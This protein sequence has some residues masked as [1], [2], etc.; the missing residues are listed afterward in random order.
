MVPVG[1]AKRM[2]E[3]AEARMFWP[4]GEV[5]CGGHLA[6]DFLLD[7]LSGSTGDACAVCSEPS[8][9]FVDLDQLRDLVVGVVRTYRRRAIDELYHDAES[10]SGYAFPDRWMEDTADVVHELFGDALDEHLI[11]PVAFALDQQY[12]FRP[13]LLWLEGAELYME[14]WSS[15]RRLVASTD[16]ELDALLGGVV[17]L[18]SRHSSDV[19]QPSQVLPELLTV[20]EDVGVVRTLAPEA[21]WHRALHVPRGEALSARRL[22][23]APSDKSTENRMNRAGAAMFYGAEDVP[24][25]DAEI[26]VAP[27]GTSAVV[28]TWK[29][30]RPLVV[31]DLVDMGEAP[32]FYDVER[33][34]LRWR[35]LFLADFA[36]DVSQPVADHATAEYRATQLLM[37]YVRSRVPELD[38]I[39]YRSSRTGRRCCAVDVANTSCVEAHE[40]GDGSA[41]QL[42]LLGSASAAH[43]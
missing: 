28:G 22:G 15:F 39:V 9:P 3:D 36:T 41:L 37:E 40:V 25:A 10:E 21:R 1:L 18:P 29:A 12:W 32:H 6:D 27:H 7:A 4:T 42:V 23:T 5:V 16:V 33:V 43:R 24:T 26:G 19:M 30:S 2:M 11:E 31:L 14:S 13:G 20:I 34:W 38:G 17:D 8:P 35:H